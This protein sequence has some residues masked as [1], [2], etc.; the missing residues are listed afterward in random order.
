MTVEIFELKDYS[1]RS[2]IEQ[3]CPI[4]VLLKVDQCSVL[5]GRNCEPLAKTIVLKGN[6]KL[7]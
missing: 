4:L 6:V 1:D 3:N 2:H 7:S 5:T